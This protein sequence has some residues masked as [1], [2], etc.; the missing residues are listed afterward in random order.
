MLEIFMSDIH[1]NYE[2]PA[3]MKLARRI[4]RHLKPDSIFLGGDIIDCAAISRFVKAPIDSLSLQDEFDYAHGKLKQ[5]REE[6]PGAVIQYLDGNHEARL[7]KYLCSNAKELHSLRDLNIP[8]QLQLA[9]LDIEHHPYMS[10][11][12]VGK[13]W[14]VHGDMLGS[15]PNI[16]RTV[17]MKVQTSIIFGHHH[18]IGM[19]FE[20]PLGKPT[21]CAIANGTLARLD[22]EWLIHPAWQQGLTLVDYSPSGY[23]HA[24]PVVFFR[25]GSKIIANVRGKEFSGDV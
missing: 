21:S 17:Y 22:P 6:S 24:E 8:R 13:L 9:D 23:F 12:K 7:N 18:K 3:A 11:V 14:H 15:G 5:L 16:A 10:K 4:I 2:D 19:H 20:T 1:Y 25:Q